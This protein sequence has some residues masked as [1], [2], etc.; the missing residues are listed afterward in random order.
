MNRRVVGWSSLMT[1]TALPDGLQ[2]RWRRLRPGHY[3]ALTPT[4]TFEAAKHSN[5]WVLVSRGWPGTER[6]QSIFINCNGALPTR[7]RR[8]GS[9]PASDRDEDEPLDE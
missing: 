7:P 5:Y 3:V 2:P 8:R 6:S 9:R 1:G 4:H